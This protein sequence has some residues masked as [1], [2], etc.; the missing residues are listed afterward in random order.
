MQTGYTSILSARLMKHMI[1]Y[2]CEFLAPFTVAQPYPEAVYCIKRAVVAVD[3]CVSSESAR[4]VELDM[5]GLRWAGI[6][7]KNALSTK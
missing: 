4:Q 2:A 6:D 7:N 5:F 1:Q 3:K